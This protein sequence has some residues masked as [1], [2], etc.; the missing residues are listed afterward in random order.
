MLQDNDPRRPGR[1]L[2]VTGHGVTTAMGL[3]H[4]HA[5][6]VGGG[7]EVAIACRRIYADARPRSRGFSVV[8]EAMPPAREDP[9]RAHIGKPVWLLRGA[10]GRD[11]GPGHFRRV[12]AI[13]DGVVGDLV[14]ATLLEDD[15][16]ATVEPFKT[17]KRGIW[18]GRSF[19]EPLPD[20]T[21][22]VRDD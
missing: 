1:I 12:R 6:P 3:D 14:H 9:L 8:D 11:S 13:L 22:G 5:R 2:E 10:R 7:R 17:G 21:E 4:V 18:H 20:Q 15:A 19:V 16:E